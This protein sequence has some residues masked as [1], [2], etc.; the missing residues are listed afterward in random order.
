MPASGL[1][2]V[3]DVLEGR[4]DLGG[5]LVD[6][7]GGWVILFVCPL[8]FECVDFE[9]GVCAKDVLG[10]VAGEA[11]DGGEEG[12]EFLYIVSER[13][14]VSQGILEKDKLHV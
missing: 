4:L 2:G 13:V 7:V 3:D 10:C 8:H 1:D 9:L 5:D 11:T 14:L 12:E 6:L